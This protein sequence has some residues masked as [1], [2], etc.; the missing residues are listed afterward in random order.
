MAV[1]TSDELNA[2]VERVKQAQRV[3]D[4]FTQQQVDKILHAA[5]LAAADARVPL[6]KMA[7]AES[8]MGVAEDKVIKNHFASEYIWIFSRI[9]LTT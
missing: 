1:T 9:G 5:A 4:G 7:V 6:A 3:Y 2:L 8:G